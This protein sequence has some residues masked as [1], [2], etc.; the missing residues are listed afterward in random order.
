MGEIRSH[1]AT[2]Q[3]ELDKLEARIATEAH[4][5]TPESAP[6]LAGFLK[7]IETRRAFLQMEMDR[8][9]KEAARIEGRLFET[10]TEV[11]SNEAVLDKTLVEQRREE[12]FAETVALEEVARNRY[13]K[14]MRG[15]N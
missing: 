12:E 7:A 15:E 11:R 3:A 6:F 13:L 4:I 9:D 5:T 2:I 10:Y 1:Q 14:Q 8:L